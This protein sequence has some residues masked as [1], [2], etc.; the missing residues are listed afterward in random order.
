MLWGGYEREEKKNSLAELIV[1]HIFDNKPKNSNDAC[2]SSRNASN[3][4][5]HHHFV[6]VFVVYI[7]E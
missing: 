1:S 7:Y 3:T 2:V 6:R 4:L 5:I